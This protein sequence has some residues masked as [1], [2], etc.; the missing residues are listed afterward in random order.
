MTAS[1]WLMMLNQIE[2]DTRTT[3]PGGGGLK[4]DR[5]SLPQVNSVGQSP[6]ELS[7]AHFLMD[8]ETLRN[9]LEYQAEMETDTGVEEPLFRLMVLDRHQLKNLYL[10]SHMPRRTVRVGGS[11]LTKQQAHEVRAGL[12]NCPGTERPASKQLSST[13]MK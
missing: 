9:A 5:R 11:Q 4:Y 13:D 7:I 3:V 1:R 2:L 6:D 10:I 8:A 12:E